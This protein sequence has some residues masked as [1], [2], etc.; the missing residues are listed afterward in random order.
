MNLAQLHILLLSII[1]ILFAIILHE[2]AHGYAAKLR[3]DYTAALL[4]RLSLNPI[5]HIDPIGTVLVPCILFFFSGFIFG[6]AKPVPIDWRN[7][8]NPRRDMAIVA[9]AG[10]LANFLMAICWGIV[11]KIAV[12]IN[13]TPNINNIFYMMGNIGIWINILLMVLNLLPI[14]P[15]DGGHI[16]S[17]F[18]PSHVALKYNQ[19][20][21][22]GLIILLVLIFLPIKGNSLLFTILTPFIH[23][24]IHLINTLLQFI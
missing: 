11:A 20:E 16:V 13:S 19:L 7:L 12:S 15:L 22:W 4:G 6:W 24:F 21:R 18:L 17:S 14:P 10:P 2:V 8:K 3:G 23:F 1:P 5:K 9:I